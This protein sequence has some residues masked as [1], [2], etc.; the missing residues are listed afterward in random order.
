[1]ACAISK[2][3]KVALWHCGNKP[4]ESRKFGSFRINVY[5]CSNNKKESR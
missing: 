4:I 1:M 5:L 2:V 3:L